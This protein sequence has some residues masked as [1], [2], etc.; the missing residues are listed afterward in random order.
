MVI[1]DTFKMTSLTEGILINKNSFE[2][3]QNGTVIHFSFQLTGI[4][5][6]TRLEAFVKT[7]YLN[8]E[9]KDVRGVFSDLDIENRL[10]NGEVDIRFES[11]K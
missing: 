6:F 10:I 3:I 2:L 5:P 7:Y 11:A 8:T 4:A 1:A 9:Q